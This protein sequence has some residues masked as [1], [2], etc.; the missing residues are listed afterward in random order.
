MSTSIENRQSRAVKR[1]YGFLWFGGLIAAWFLFG[2]KAA[3]TFRSGSPIIIFGSLLGLAL[4]LGTCVLWH[5]LSRR[6]RRR[7][8]IVRAIGLTFFLLGC[9]TP[10]FM[11]E[12]TGFGGDSPALGLD[13]IV[14]WILV[15][16]LFF[17]PAYFLCFGARNTSPD[18]PT[19]VVGD[20]SP[21]AQSPLDGSRR[22]GSQ[23]ASG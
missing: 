15:Y 5:V 12:P 21:P 3:W 14:M 6:R 1:S 4:A 22:K 10:M 7:T 20:D 9:L 19:D 23:Q 11:V 17:T 13:T 16:V 2:G 18:V 8:Q